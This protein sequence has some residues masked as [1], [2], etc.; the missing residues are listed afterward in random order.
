MHALFVFS[1]LEFERKVCENFDGK[2]DYISEV[3][4]MAHCAMAGMTLQE[5]MM[6]M[7]K[8]GFV[9]EQVIIC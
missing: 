4:C 8:L 2:P 5:I 7:E 6:R 1:N 9:K 3:S